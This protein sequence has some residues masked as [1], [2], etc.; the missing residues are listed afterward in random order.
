MIGS[1]K[2]E[3]H[4][5]VIQFLASNA[6]SLDRKEYMRSY[7]NVV[8]GPESIHLTKH[9]LL[10]A[11]LNHYPCKSVGRQ[12]FVHIHQCIFLVLS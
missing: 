11:V 9:S 3:I 8:I 5:N 7:V 10:T 4:L 12:D 2:I 6:T 1:E